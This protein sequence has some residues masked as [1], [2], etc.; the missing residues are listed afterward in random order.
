VAGNILRKRFA[1]Y[2]LL[3]YEHLLKYWSTTV[4]SVAVVALLLTSF[5]HRC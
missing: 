4:N 1:S 3:I 5:L 2:F